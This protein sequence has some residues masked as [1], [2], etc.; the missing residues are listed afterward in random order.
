MSEDGRPGGPGQLG[1]YAVA[2]IGYGAMAVGQGSAE[3]AM[4]LLRRAVELGV[5]HFDT[6]SFYDDGEVNRR[7]R[8]ALSP[9]PRDV[10]IV[11]KVGAI[12]TPGETPPLALAQG[13]RTCARRSSE[14]SHNWRSSKCRW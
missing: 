8:Q 9:Y 1:A 7:I 10:V 2:R 13:P 3:D 11:S 14:I 12:S 6:A 4:S 5:N